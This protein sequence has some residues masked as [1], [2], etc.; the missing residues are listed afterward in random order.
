MVDHSQPQI[1]VVVVFYRKNPRNDIFGHLLIF[2]LD[3]LLMLANTGE[4]C[5]PVLVRIAQYDWEGVYSNIT[6]S[7]SCTSTWH[8]FQSLPTWNEWLKL[9]LLHGPGCAK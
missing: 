9:F 2:V 8:I 7:T 1:F 3:C 4:T 6:Y 5:V